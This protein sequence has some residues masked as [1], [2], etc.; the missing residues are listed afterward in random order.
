MLRRAAT[1]LVP[2][3][4]LLAG[5]GYS[6]TK[7]INVAAPATPSAW[8]TLRY[9]AAGVS[10]RAPQNWIL[11][12]GR[13]QL[14]VAIAS[15]LARV[16][17]WRYPRKEPL[18]STRSALRQARRALVVAARARDPHLRVI[19]ARQL[20]VAGAHA[21]ELSA[22]EL[23]GGQLRRDRSLHLF[24]GGAE[25]VLDVYAPV[26]DFHAAD[27]AVFS[28]LKRSLQLFPAAA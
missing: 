3:F 9:P 5:C 12:A 7:P 23:I 24:A 26:N 16:E 20:T 10:I 6:Q 13:G 15:G 2:V 25:L 1:V 19:R 28:P 14:V 18:P 11:G 17:L 8:R 21:I 27:H 4:A 22:T